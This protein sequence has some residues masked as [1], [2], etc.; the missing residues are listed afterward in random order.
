MSSTCWATFGNSSETS[1]PHCPYFLKLHGDGIR[2]PGVPIDRA[3]SPTPFIVSPWC[4]SRSG[5][6]SN[7]S[8][9]LTPP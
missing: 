8:T 9:W 7:V 1:I 6:G 4:F 3:T 2:P 5:F